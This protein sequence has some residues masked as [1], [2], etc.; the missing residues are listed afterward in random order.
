MVELYSGEMW[1]TPSC[2]TDFYSMKQHRVLL[3]P[4]RCEAGLSQGSP[5]LPLPQHFVSCTWAPFLET[6]GDLPGT[7]RLDFFKSAFYRLVSIIN[8]NLSIRFIKLK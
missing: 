4:P 8:A 1:L 7:V 6:P 5:P 2:L 3:V